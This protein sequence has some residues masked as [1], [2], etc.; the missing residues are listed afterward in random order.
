MLDF[1]ELLEIN[2]DLTT[3]SRV[4]RTLYT[5]RLRELAARGETVT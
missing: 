2:A 1:S 4:F 5:S 3:D